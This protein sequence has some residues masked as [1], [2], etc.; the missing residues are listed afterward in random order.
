MSWPEFRRWG[1][2]YQV[3]PW[4]EDLADLRNAL[5]RKDVC[6]IMGG[7]AIQNEPVK[8]FMA[9]PDRSQPR[10]VMTND[11]MR[12]AFMVGKAQHN[13]AIESAGHPKFPA[14]NGKP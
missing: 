1:A 13:A 11:Q 14:H 9:H 10:P 4:G 12:A 2:Y 7:K 8:S 3:E 6:M 5:L